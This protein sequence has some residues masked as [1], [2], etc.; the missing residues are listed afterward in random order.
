[1]QVGD[2]CEVIG[3]ERNGGII[4][5]EENDLL[6]EHARD[7]LMTGSVV[8][9]LVKD[10]GRYYYK[11]LYGEGPWN[12]W[13]AA[14]ANRKNILKRL[15]GED[16]EAFREALADLDSHDI[17]VAV[18]RSPAGATMSDVLDA[19]GDEPLVHAARRTSS[20]S[21][22]P[23]S[24]ATLPT[25]FGAASTQRPTERALVR[26]AC[27]HPHPESA[28]SAEPD[29]GSGRKCQRVYHLP[30]VT[31]PSSDT[32]PDSPESAAR[33]AANKHESRQD[34][35]SP[36][37]PPIQSRRRKKDESPLVRSPCG[38]VS[39]VPSARGSPDSMGSSLSAATP[40]TEACSFVARASL[41]EPGATSALVSSKIHMKPVALITRPATAAVPW[42]SGK[43]SPSPRR[44]STIFEASGSTSCVGP[45][46][47]STIVAKLVSKAACTS[48]SSSSPGLRVEHDS[49][50]VPHSGSESRRERIIR[51]WLAACSMRTSRPISL[52]PAAVVLLVE[53]SP[54]QTAA[55]VSDLAELITDVAPEFMPSSPTTS[56]PPPSQCSSASPVSR[57]VVPVPASPGSLSP[58]PNLL[59][60]MSPPPSRA[61]QEVKKEAENK[62]PSIEAA[63]PKYNYR[64]VT[65]CIPIRE[66]PHVDAEAL[67]QARRGEEYNVLELDTSKRWVRIDL[68]A[69][70]TLKAKYYKDLGQPLALIP[71]WISV[72]D[73]VSGTPTFAPLTDDPV[74][75][76][77]SPP[78]IFS[79]VLSKLRK[80]S[81]AL[82][83][84]APLAGA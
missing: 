30:D 35:L 40:S 43:T 34:A 9:I 24:V 31:T 29:E 37:T 19:I 21:A 41:G 57:C 32:W 7:R 49:S 55:P 50:P 23:R 77:L 64:V 67:G 52:P 22:A 71:G 27:S 6:S 28:A 17:N 26:E 66:A 81:G 59:P 78:K 12:G 16:A 20:R 74:S 1:M 3:G 61:E 2:I 69:K 46:A 39:S 13:V 68:S 63:I 48:Q 65:S 70:L 75:L 18:P 14:R 44:S 54:G 60:H 10:G 73:A 83:A 45:T 84:L 4:V 51:R 76:C 5:R 42:V 62:M 38:C 36:S 80:R 79:G 15:V 58:V 47:V 11:K 33:R 53:P 8:L 56:P 82:R 72:A 25:L